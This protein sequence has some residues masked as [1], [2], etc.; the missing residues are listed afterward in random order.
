MS[1]IQYT[2][3]EN[4]LSQVLDLIGLLIPETFTLPYLSNTTGASRDT[5][6]KY[7]QRNHIEGMDYKKKDGKIVVCREI[8]LELLRRY[9]NA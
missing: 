7:L 1:D 2:N 4:Q 8:G 5:I 6:Y 9:K 3:I